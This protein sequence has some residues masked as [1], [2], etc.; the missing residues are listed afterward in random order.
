MRIVIGP[1]F[2]KDAD[3]LDRLADHFEMAGLSIPATLI[4]AAAVFM[5]DAAPCLPPGKRP[6]LRVVSSSRSKARERGQL[7][8]N[9]RRP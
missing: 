5:R 6:T 3:E 2:R 7:H 1:D 4:G 9:A 8:E